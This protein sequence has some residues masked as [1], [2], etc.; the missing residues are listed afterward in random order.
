MPRVSDHA[1]LRFMERA[2]DMDV[3]GLRAAVE[4][5]LERAARTAAA[6]GISDYT[7]KADGLIYVIRSDVVVTVVNRSIP[8]EEDFR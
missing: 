1:L 8:R 3:A 2:G 6:L 4:L 5:S 7:I